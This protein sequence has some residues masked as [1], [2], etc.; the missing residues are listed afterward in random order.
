MRGYLSSVTPILHA[1][2]G[3]ATLIDSLVVE[4]SADSK[5]VLRDIQVNQRLVVE[6]KDAKEWAKSGEEIDSY[7]EEITPPFSFAHQM[8]SDLDDYS[9]QPLLVL[10]LSD[11]GPA[12][13]KGDINGD[14]LDDVFVG[15]GIGQEAGIFMQNEEGGFDRS[16]Q[17]S[18]VSHRAP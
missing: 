16:N 13:E 4:W 11:V 6:Q 5:Q 12:L 10:P 8:P 3:Q 18:F 1:G 17:P 15:G 2:L 7:L 14:G 9:R